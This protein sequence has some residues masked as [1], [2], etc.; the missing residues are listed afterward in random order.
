MRKNTVQVTKLDNGLTVATDTIKTVESVSVGVWAGSGARQETKANNGIAHFLEHMVFKGTETRSAREIAEAIENVGGFMNAYTSYEMTAYYAR[1][2]KE[3]MPLAFDIVSDILR[4]PAFEKNEMERERGVI[5]QEIGMRQDS[6]DTLV[7]DMMQDTAFGDT[8]LGWPVIGSADVVKTAT[9]DMIFDFMDSNYYADNL[10]LAASGNINHD[11][12]VARATKHFGDLKNSG[13][14]TSPKAVYLGGDNR[15]EK[16]LEQVHLVLGF[17]SANYLDDDYYAAVVLGT[18]M[19]GGM[20]SRLFQEIREKRGLVYSVYSYN[21]SYCDTGLF[22][23]YAGTGEKEIA[24]LLPI[25]CDTLKTAS[26]S[27]TDAEIKRAK[28]QIR[29]GNLMALESTSSRCDKLGRSILSHGKPRSVDEIIA[30]VDAVSTDDLN[31]VATKI[32]SG[33]PSLS[34]IGPIKNLDPYDKV[35]KR[36]IG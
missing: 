36:F 31:R 18:L 34:A 22:E 32:F 33:K 5:L 10:V 12:L 24:E 2:L 25:L 21:A 35:E 30:K 14:N 1:V 4:K 16:D 17:E 27:F 15:V 29:S 19:G 8:P 3:D 28:A 20:S 9:R 7:F 13:T 11:D 23:I 26:G 6:P